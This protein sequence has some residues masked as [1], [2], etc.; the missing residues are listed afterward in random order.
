[1]NRKTTLWKTILKIQRSGIMRYFTVLSSIEVTVVSVQVINNFYLNTYWLQ[2]YL[3]SKLFFQE[4]QIVTLVPQ[5]FIDLF[6]NKKCEQDPKNE[7]RS[8]AS[9]HSLTPR[10]AGVVAIIYYY[11]FESNHK[12]SCSKNGPERSCGFIWGKNEKKKIDRVHFS[13]FSIFRI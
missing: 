5:C 4:L 1:M 12:S 11:D 2:F 8:L 9:L 10:L 3:Y 7:S 13:V 6:Q